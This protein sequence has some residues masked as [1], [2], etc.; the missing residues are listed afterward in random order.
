MFR[1]VFA[2]EL[3]T[4]FDRESVIRNLAKLLKQEEQTVR[5]RLFA[6][7]PV[8]VKKVDTKEQALKWRKAFANAGAVLIVLKQAGEDASAQESLAKGS[9]AGHLPAEREPAPSEQPSLSMD[10]QDASDTPIDVDEDDPSATHYEEPTPASEAARSAGIRKRNKVYVLLGAVAL[11]LIVV[12]V[13]VLWSTKALWQGI[14]LEPNRRDL[15]AALLT[16]QT[17]ALARVDIDRLKALEELSGRAANLSAL[18]GDTDK[19]FDSLAAAGID[20]RAQ[21][22]YLWLAGYA[23]GRKG[24][25]LMV[26]EGQFDA[27]KLS[28]WL[29]ERYSVEQPLPDGL[30]FTT[31]NEST[32]EKSEPR[33]ALIRDDL[34]V[35]GGPEAVEAFAQRLEQGVAI[36][37]QVQHW[38]DLSAEQLASLAVFEPANIGKAAGGMPGFML[39]SLGAA[40]SPASGLYL[41]AETV[42]LPPGVELSVLVESQDEDFLNQ[43]KDAIDARL[44]ELRQQAATNF[45]ETLSLYDRLSVN[46]TDSGVRAAMRFDENLYRELEQWINSLFSQAFS[47][48]GDDQAPVE[49]QLDEDPPVFTEQSAEPKPFEHFSALSDA[50][51]K[52]VAAVGPFAL[53][54]DSLELGEDN[55]IHVNLSARAYELPNVP[56]RG[57]AAQLY[58]GDVVDSAGESLLVVPECGPDANRDAGDIGNPINHSSYIDG[59]MVSYLRVSGEKSIVLREGTSLGAI[60]QLSG[61]IRYPQVT[62]TER[63]RLRQPLAGQ[64]VEREGVQIR[65]MESGK[66]SLSYRFSGD[67]DRLLHVAALNAQGQPLSSGGALWGDVLFGAGKSA[68]VDFRGEIA[69]VEV[70]LASDIEERRYPFTL[71]RLLPQPQASDFPKR[72]QSWQDAGSWSALAEAEPP[73]V[74]YDWS[75]PAQEVSVGPVLMAVNEASASGG[76]GFSLAADLYVTNQIPLHTLLSGVRLSVDQLVLAGGEKRA[77]EVTGFAAFSHDGGYWMNG[78]YQPDDERPWLKAGVR[79]GDRDIKAQEAQAIEGHLSIAIPES[80]STHELAFDLGASWSSD[81]FSLTVTKFTAEALYLSFSGDISALIGVEAYA[82]KQRVSEQAEL[83]QFFGDAQIKLPLTAVPSH[84]IIEVGETVQRSRFEFTA[85]L[86]P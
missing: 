71:D 38:Y 22:S 9:P 74:S 76:F 29:G 30:L 52:P 42:A 82:D 15:G 53:A 1:L 31:T 51:F 8:A 60:A 6:G 58:I 63:I 54:V 27:S 3:I 48:G 17:Y 12:I 84:L 14:E 34:L 11:A 20:M 83:E 13:L 24:D 59:E 69:S 49:E 61:Y 64:V 65:F 81:D 72:Q 23:S 55:R 66:H 75:Q 32:C 86:E 36:A 47:M 85:T 67:T 41:G 78:E 44:S 50:F 18:P 43:S 80:A 33:R 7:Q 5:E 45:P 57:A 25:G 37:P 21:S 39:K 19:L 62:A 77:V 46:R 16:P 56:G 40:A 26:V 4:G 73:S 35:I 70:V 10:S 68:S 79:L 2:G 28:R